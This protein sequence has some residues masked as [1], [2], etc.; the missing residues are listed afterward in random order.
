V[1]EEVLSLEVYSDSWSTV[2]MSEIEGLE[3][4]AYSLAASS[5]RGIG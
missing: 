3:M 4:F 1:A 2:V 5:F